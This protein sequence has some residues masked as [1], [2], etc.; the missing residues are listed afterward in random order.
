MFHLNLASLGLHKEELVTSLSLLNFE[1]DVIAVTETKIRTGV[2]PIFDP[3]LPGYQHFQTPTECAKGGT[4]I[5]TKNHIN[6]KRR[7]DLETIMYKSKEL[8]TSLHGN[9]RIQQSLFWALFGKALT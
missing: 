3:S 4:I 7:T 9:R 2:T 1:F 5:Y 8:E 6:R